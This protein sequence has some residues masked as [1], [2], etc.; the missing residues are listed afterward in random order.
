MKT[1]PRCHHPDWYEGFNL[2]ECPNRECPDFTEKA[3]KLH[4]EAERER[5]G[6]REDTQPMIQNPNRWKLVFLDAGFRPSLR[7]FEL[8]D[9]MLWATLTDP[10]D[11]ARVDVGNYA[12]ISQTL[13][14]ME[15]YRAAEI[16]MVDRAGGLFRMGPV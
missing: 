4:L 3:L 12:T 14:P 1:C 8:E 9:G 7:S 10:R 11:I 5:R 6:N 13:G 2:V 16:N 15:I